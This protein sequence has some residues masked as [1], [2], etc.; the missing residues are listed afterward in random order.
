MCKS[1]RTV[2][3]VAPH[4][5]PSNL[6]GV[7]RARLLSQHLHEFG[8]R[9]IILAAHWRHYEETLDWGLASLIDPALEIVHT[10]AFPT[11]PV[12]AIG[13]IGVRALPWHLAALRRLRREGRLDFLLITVP[14]FYSAVLGELLY[15]TEPLPF[16]IDYIDPWV[17]Q[18]P[19]AKSKYSKAWASMKLGERLEPWAVR[20]AVLITGVAEGYYE[21]VLQR[22]PHLRDRCVTA[23]M[24]YGF[25]TRDFDSPAVAEKR[26]YLFNPSDGN[27]HVVYAGALLPKGGAVL[28]RLL[29]ALALL[30]QRGAKQAGRLRIH[31]IGTGKSPMDANGYN[32]L[33]A[34]ERAGVADLVS[35]H[36]HRMR[37]L[38]VLAHLKSAYGVLIVGSTEPHYSPSKVYQAVQSRRPVFALLHEAS[39]AVKVLEHSRAGM[40]VMLTEDTL[41]GAQSVS[42]SFERFLKIPY[43]P[44]A[45]QW[46]AFAAYSAR[47]SACKMAQAMDEALNRFS[48]GQMQC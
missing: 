26:P 7:H 12:R 43:D 37:Y 1:Q 29:E 14:S 46:E 19:P 30:R 40:A 23:G 2:V 27:I 38:D 42:E 16:G 18:C 11:K 47:E 4:F 9:P 24:P 6:A 48:A 25:S 33:P 32:V 10:Q 31:F 28:E 34:A 5:P 13:D 35:E 15:R 20:H 21:G 45:V 39:T 3:I 36:P 44:E 17:H 41:P 8:W 22:N